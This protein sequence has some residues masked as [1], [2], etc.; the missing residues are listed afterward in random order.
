MS[1]LEEAAEEG[2]ASS[3]CLA[4]STSMGCTDFFLVSRLRMLGKR[5]NE[6]EKGGMV[7]ERRG[8]VLV[9]AESDLVKSSCR[10]SG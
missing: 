10:G 1:K 5:P 8:V 6:D 9:N 2:P 7:T 3:Y 4:T